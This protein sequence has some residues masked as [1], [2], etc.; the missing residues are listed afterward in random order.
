MVTR[1]AINRF[2]V[3]YFVATKT[4]PGLLEELGAYTSVDAHADP[5][6]GY[7]V[8]S[9]YWDTANLSF[10]WEKI[11]G[12]KSRRK[13]RFRRYGDSDE[14]YIEVKQRDDRTLRKRRLKWPLDRVVQVFGRG[15]GVDW[16]A[17]GDEPVARE[18]AVMVDRLA[19]RPTMGVSY[20]RRALFGRFD[21][22]LRVTVDS[23]LMYQPAPVDLA[24]PF[25]AGS[26]ILD[27]RV[28]VLEIKYDNRVPLW[29]T[30]FVCRHGLKIVRM[31]KYCS[32]IDLH[33]FGGQNT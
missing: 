7:E 9:V 25:H 5:R 13:V 24:R 30:K 22:E 10:F 3:K 16:D 31:S 21:P 4:V 14:V 29:L 26:Y 12:V 17:L 11:E 18:V 1:H 32:A 19:L 15:R 20:R 2:E 23:R 8:F 6:H 27:P 33:R 28:S